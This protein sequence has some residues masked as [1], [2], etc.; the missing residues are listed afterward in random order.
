LVAKEYISAKTDSDG[1]LLLSPFT[2]AA[3]ELKGALLVNP[4]ATDEFAHHIQ[5]AVEM[6]HEERSSRMKKLREI[7]KEK[8]IYLWADRIL[9][10]AIQIS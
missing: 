10:K 8:N 7:V 5:R 2:G 1:V 6:A 3:R 4:Y 9:S